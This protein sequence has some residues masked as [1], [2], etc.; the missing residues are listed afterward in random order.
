MKLPPG[1]RVADYV[2]LSSVVKQFV[3]SGD[4]S[5]QPLLRSISATNDL[6]DCVEEREEVSRANCGTYQAEGQ[7]EGMTSGTSGS[8]R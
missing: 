5:T 6:F 4:P 1:F 7:A 3:C 2:S 8:E